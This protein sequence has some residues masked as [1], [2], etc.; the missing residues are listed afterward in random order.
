MFDWKNYCLID[1]SNRKYINFPNYDFCTQNEFKN[2]S[3]KS[4]L[5]TSIIPTDQLDTDKQ[6]H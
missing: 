6:T 1:I 3:M 2:E 4:Y 5:P